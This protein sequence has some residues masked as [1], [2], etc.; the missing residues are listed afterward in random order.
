MLDVGDY[1][2]LK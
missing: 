2:A 1:Y